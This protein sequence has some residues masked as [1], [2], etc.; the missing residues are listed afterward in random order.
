MSGWALELQGYQCWLSSLGI[1]LSTSLPA[2]SMIFQNNLWVVVNPSLSWSITQHMLTGSLWPSTTLLPAPYITKAYLKVGSLWSNLI[3]SLTIVVLKPKP[4]G[5]LSISSIF[6]PLLIF[7]QFCWQLCRWALWQT[8]E[9]WNVQGL[10]HYSLSCT[11]PHRVLPPTRACPHTP[12]F[13]KH[14]SWWNFYNIIEVSGVFYESLVYKNSLLV[15]FLRNQSHQVEPFFF[16]FC[17]QYL[18]CKNTSS[19]PW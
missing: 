9:V 11:G 17:L 4:L 12:F 16:F 1:F 5:I 7:S 13:F 2:I 8:Y 6:S 14:N 10:Q 3:E 19:L 15:S 18:A